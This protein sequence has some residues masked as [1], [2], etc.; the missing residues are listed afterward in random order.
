MNI[1]LIRYVVFKALK[2]LLLTNQKAWI[3]SNTAVSTPNLS[4]Y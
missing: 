1:D 3:F 4:T 2:I